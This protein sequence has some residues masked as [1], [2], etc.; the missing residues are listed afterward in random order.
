MLTVTFEKKSTTFE[1]IYLCGPATLVFE[2]KV[3]L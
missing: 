1:N 3:E 2:G